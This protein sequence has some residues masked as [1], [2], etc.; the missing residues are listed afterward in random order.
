MLTNLHYQLIQ[1]SYVTVFIGHKDPQRCFLLALIYNLMWYLSYYSFIQGLNTG[2]N[3][4]ICWTNVENT[5]S[6]L[7]PAQK[8]FYTF[9]WFKQFKQNNKW[10]CL[11]GQSI[12]VGQSARLFTTTYKGQ[13]LENYE[14]CNQLACNAANS[15][16]SNI[17]LQDELYTF[18]NRF[19]VFSED[20]WFKCKCGQVVGI[21]KEG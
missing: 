4:D 8:L 1:Y 14:W 11:I 2:W 17:Q 12:F 10:R 3:I 5:F 9:H 15:A 19:C 6:F 20:A 18:I 13:S 16:W 21:F 7:W